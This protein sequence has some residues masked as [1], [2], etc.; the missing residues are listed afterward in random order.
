MNDTE[1]DSISFTHYK[2]PNMLFYEDRL[3]TFQNWSRQ[4]KPDKYS[5]AKAGFYYT[6]TGDKVRCFSCGVGVMVWEPND[7]PWTEHAKWSENC[8]YLKMTGHDKGSMKANKKTVSFGFGSTTQQQPQNWSS[9]TA[10]QNNTPASDFGAFE[11]N[12]SNGFGANLFIG[13]KRIFDN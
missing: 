3:Q 11:S 7:D 9:A 13:N 8:V 5:L 12:G 4:I 2:T 1:T 6:G 10:F